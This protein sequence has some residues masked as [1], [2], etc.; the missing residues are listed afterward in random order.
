ML[1][2]QAYLNET[3]RP[4]PPHAPLVVDLF[5][6]CG[7]FA[8]GFEAVGFETVGFENNEYACKT[9]NENLVGV[10]NK[11][12]ITASS[13]FP[14]AP[15]IIGG[16]P[17]QPFSV[18]G[19]QRGLDDTRNGMPAFI[20]AVQRNQP[21]IWILENVRGLLYR[22]KWYL[23]EILQE[24]R[25]LGYLVEY[26]LIN[27][28]DYGVPQNRERLFIVGH[29]GRFTFPEPINNRVPI[30]EVIGDT[31]TQEIIGAKFLTASMDEYIAKYERASQC[32]VPRDLRLDRVSRTV[33]CRNL[34]GATGD[35]LRV[36]LPDGRRRRLSVREGAWLQ[37]FPDWYTFHGSETAQYNQIGNAVPPLLAYHFAESVRLYLNSAYRLPKEE[38]QEVAMSN[39]ERTPDVKQLALFL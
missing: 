13:I 23:L 33:T 37:S 6:G 10:C 31:A 7:G 8:L 39:T 25:A 19:H 1:P 28:A 17:C 18:G 16:P 11:V 38:L 35:M 21:D 20:A 26:R 14:E 32:I 36:R 2:Y 12:H 9:Y 30:A 34:A 29:R 27:A 3:L 24:L 4:R 15:V 22:N 5:A